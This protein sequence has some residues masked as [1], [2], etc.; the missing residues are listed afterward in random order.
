MPQFEAAAGR[1]RK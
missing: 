1:S